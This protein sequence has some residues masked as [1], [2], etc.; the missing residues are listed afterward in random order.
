[1]FDRWS[2]I[3]IVVLT[4]A[5][6]AGIP[7]YR[8]SQDPPL[9]PAT[10]SLPSSGFERLKVYSKPLPVSAPALQ[11]ATEQPRPLAAYAGQP[12]ILNFWATWCVPCVREMPALNRLQPALAAEN[13]TVL[14]AAQDR[15]GAAVV[16]AF[17]EKY[18]LSNLPVLLDGNGEVG[19]ALSVRGLPTTVFLNA[20]GQEVA[21]LEGV[22]DWDAPEA[23]AAIAQAF[24]GAPR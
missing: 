1:M 8:F 10:L 17:N 23:R 16:Q 3:G 7:L 24:A 18:A 15:G 4:V 5:V 13:I 6:G 20:A 21:R 9:D 12:V 2:I 22:A 11:D 19:R 14:A